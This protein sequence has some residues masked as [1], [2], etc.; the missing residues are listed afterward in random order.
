MRSGAL[1]LVVT[2]A[3][4]A[5]HPAPAGP[6]P[7][8]ETADCP[9]PAGAPPPPLVTSSTPPGPSVT[10]SDGSRLEGIILLAVPLTHHSVISSPP[11][12]SPELDPEFAVANALYR[13]AHA[14]YVAADYPRSA[15]CFVRAALSLRPVTRRKSF[16]AGDAAFDRAAY[17]R[18]AVYAWVMAET[19]DV[20]RATLDRLEQR[21]RIP[22]AELD[23]PRKLLAAYAPATAP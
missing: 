6:R 3:C 10:L 13:G 8:Y 22:A 12:P 14:A 5:G 16:F 1:A 11:A 7:A 4:C 15:S 20:A 18:N 2:A 17:L 21:E 9:V 19:L 23:E